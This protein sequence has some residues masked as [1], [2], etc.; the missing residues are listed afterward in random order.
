MTF[1]EKWEME[2]PG[3]VLN[4]Y[5]EK[6]PSEFGYETGADDGG[7]NNRGITCAACWNREIPEVK[8]VKEV[9]EVYEPRPAFPSAP[10]ILDS[11]DRTQ[12]E[13]GAVRDMHEG[14]GRMDLLP[15]AAL[16]EVSK[17]CENG[18]KK[19]GEHNADGYGIPTHSFADSALRHMAKYLDGWEDE[20]HL[21]AAAWNILMLIEMEINHPE[22]VDTPFKKYL[23][24]YREGYECRDN[25]QSVDRE[26]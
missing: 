4:T 25:I 23:S 8:E 16:M 19:Y 12:F 18:A 1:K 24:K 10:Q 14:K 9:K 13:T 2:H 22:C 5:M 11:G 17:H 7:C 15:W 3:R 20:N 26:T 21:V 6:C